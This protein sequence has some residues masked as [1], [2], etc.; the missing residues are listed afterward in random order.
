LSPPSAAFFLSSLAYYICVLSEYKNLYREHAIDKWVE[1]RKA[2]EAER[3][4]KKKAK[5]DKKKAAEG[6]DKPEGEED[7]KEGD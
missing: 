7:K 4:A 2:E 6:G 5:E 3:E 1:E